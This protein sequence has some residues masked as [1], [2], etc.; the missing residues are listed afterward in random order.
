MKSFKETYEMY[1]KEESDATIAARANLHKSTLSRM[2]SEAIPANRNY[3][4]SLAMALELTLEKTDELFAASGL[5]MRSKYHL[6]DREK[7]R[8][9]IIEECIRQKK[10]SVI[11]LNIRLYDAGYKLLGNKGIR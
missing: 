1:R 10:Y 5:C 9:S 6:T 4:W 11:D 8:E 3:L 7:K 2:K